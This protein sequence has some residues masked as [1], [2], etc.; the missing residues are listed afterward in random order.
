NSAINSSFTQQERNETVSSFKS[1]QVNILVATNLLS[2]GIDI[3]DVNL[4]VNYDIPEKPEDYVHRIGRTARAGKL[5]LA[6]SFISEFEIIK[7]NRIEKLLGRSI[8]KIAL[9]DGFEKAPKYSI[10]NSAGNHRKKPR[11]FNSGK[12]KQISVNTKKL[13]RRS[14][15]AK[16]E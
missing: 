8:D 9:P 1:G 13:F 16:N 7:F 10:I 4:I 11:H 5:G 3:E 15:S 14:D 2:R 12:S 6:I